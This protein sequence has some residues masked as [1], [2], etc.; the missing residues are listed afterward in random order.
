MNHGRCINCWWYQAVRGRG[1]KTTPLGLVENLGGGKCYMH[2][3]GT[4]EKVD[5]SLVDGSS[6]CPDYYNRKRGNWEQGKT[7]EEWINED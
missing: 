1:C 2:N 4:G 6:Y 3:S 5:Y 7:L